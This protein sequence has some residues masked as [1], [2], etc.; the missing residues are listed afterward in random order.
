MTDDSCRGCSAG[1][2]SRF[3]SLSFKSHPFFLVFA[4]WSF[5][6][7]L[8]FGIRTLSLLFNPKSPGTG[9]DLVLVGALD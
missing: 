4:A 9:A 5:F 8:D 3:V 2:C 6:L 7:S 1:V